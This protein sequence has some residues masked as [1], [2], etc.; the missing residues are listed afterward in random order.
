MNDRIKQ[1]REAL[2]MSQEQ[3][4][5]AIG[6]TKSSISNIENRTRN[7]TEKHIK[8]I[9]SALNVNEKWLRLGY[10]EMFNK[11]SMDYFDQI[12]EYYKLDEIDKKILFEYSKLDEKKRTVIKE[13]IFSVAGSITMTSPFEKNQVVLEKSKYGKD[14]N[15]DD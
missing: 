7:V 15:E 14:E 3:F 4:G 9:C 11:K 5:S 2:N 1:I 12:A 6:L 13:Y 10:G 8:L